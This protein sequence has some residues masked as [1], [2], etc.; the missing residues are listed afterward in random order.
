MEQSLILLKGI[1]PEAAVNKGQP[2]NILEQS[3]NTELLFIDKSIAF[4]FSQLRNI[5][6]AF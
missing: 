1:F 4:K 5:Y 3:S 6:L 2:E